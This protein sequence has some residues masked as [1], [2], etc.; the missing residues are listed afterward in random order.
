MTRARVPWVALAL[1][2]ALGG[3][4]GAPERWMRTDFDPADF[5]VDDRTCRG[6]M[7]AA[8]GA[9]LRAP[10]NWHIHR[11]CLERRGYRLVPAAAQPR[12]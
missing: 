11:S 9:Q 5:A 1:L 7:Y 6:E 2:A 10:P 3:C 8:R 4:A 12:G